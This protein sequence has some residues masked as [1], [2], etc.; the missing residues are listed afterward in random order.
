[1]DF[2]KTKNF[3]F[4]KDTVEKAKKPGTDLGE[5]T[6]AKHISDKEFVSRIHKEFS[7]LDKKINPIKM[8]KIF[9]QMLHKK[10]CKWQ[11]LITTSHSRKRKLKPQ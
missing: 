11:W 4:L 5:N 10:R 9:E 6:F 8:G 1:M 2:I 3:C 7:Q